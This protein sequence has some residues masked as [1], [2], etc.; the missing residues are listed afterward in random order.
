MLKSLDGE[1]GGIGSMAAS[2]LREGEFV[3]FEMAV[4]VQ[5]VLEGTSD[6]ELAWRSQP[7]PV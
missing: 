6:W 4:L 5:E 1:P 7:G 3:V 2:C